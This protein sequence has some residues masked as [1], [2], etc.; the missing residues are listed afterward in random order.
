MV[1]PWKTNSLFI[2]F[3]A[4]VLTGVPCQQNMQTGIQHL[5]RSL[6]LLFTWPA[7]LCCKTCGFSLY[8]RWSQPYMEPDMN[9][10]YI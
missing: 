3:N 10:Y 9:I 7:L 5:W 2:P 1:W 6:F 4:W 8:K